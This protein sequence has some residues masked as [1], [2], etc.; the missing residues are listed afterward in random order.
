VTIP[1]K[2]KIF[3]AVSFWMRAGNSLC[4]PFKIF[5]INVSPSFVY[6]G[7]TDRDK[8]K[9]SEIYLKALSDGMWVKSG[10]N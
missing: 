2:A 5:L 9:Y 7:N 8:S 1:V 10:I 3:V 6:Q 4:L